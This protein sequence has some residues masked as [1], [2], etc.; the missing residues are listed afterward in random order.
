M[1]VVEGL[2][3]RLSLWMATKPFW[4]IKRCSQREQ[5]SQIYL[6]WTN[7]CGGI[8]YVHTILSSLPVYHGDSPHRPVCWLWSGPSVYMWTSSQDSNSLKAD[9]ES[10][11]P[12]SCLSM[13]KLSECTYI[14]KLEVVVTQSCPTLYYPMDCSPPG[15]SVHR[16]SQARILEWVAISFSRG[17]SWPWDWTW[18]F[19]VSSFGRGI[20]YHRTTWEAPH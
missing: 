16:I 3:T 9:S 18:D 14:Y 1:K 6:K 10:N 13:S 19:S 15:S 17:S 5:P 7:D 8:C 11:T 20:L 4:F 2:I 12:S